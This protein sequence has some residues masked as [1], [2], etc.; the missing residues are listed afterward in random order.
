MKFFICSLLSFVQVFSLHFAFMPVRFRTLLAF[1]GFFML[2]RDRKYLKLSRFEKRSWGKLVFSLFILLIVA[3]ISSLVNLNFDSHYYKYPISLLLSLCSSYAFIV[4]LYKIQK[5]GITA[6]DLMLYILIACVIQCLL[7]L[8]MFIDPSFQKVALGI[9]QQNEM[10]KQAIAVEGENRILSFGAGFFA[11]GVI[12]S[13]S[14]YFSSILINTQKSLKKVLIL[15]ICTLLIV[16]IGSAIARTTLVGLLMFFI[17]FTLSPKVSMHK[18][19]ILFVILGITMIIAIYLYFKYIEENPIFEK[20]FHRAFSVF[21]FFDKTGEIQSAD[22]TI[23]HAIYPDNMKTWIIGDGLMADPNHPEIAYYKGTDRG[24]CRV[25]LGLGGVGLFVYSLIQYYLCKLTR[26]GRLESL[27]IFVMY[28][29]FMLKSFVYMDLYVSLFI[30]LPIFQI[31]KK[32]KNKLL[33]S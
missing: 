26:L 14:L 32:N 12:F 33:Y 17:Y 6:C 8:V 23:G 7:S 2:I 19:L 15:I 25:L 20:V 24:I 4:L 18:K 3:S 27:L 9:V 21:Y 13:M 10:A 5:K 1:L 29:A 28:F 22:T 31:I 11:A 30:M 16:F